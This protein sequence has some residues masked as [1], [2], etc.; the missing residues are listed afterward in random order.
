MVNGCLKVVVFTPP[1][2]RSKEYTF[3][4]SFRL[5]REVTVVSASLVTV[6][7]TAS[8]NWDT[9][10]VTVRPLKVTAILAIP[11][12]LA[13]SMIALDSGTSTTLALTV[14]KFRVSVRPVLPG[15]AAS[16]ASKALITSASTSFRV[17]LSP[18]ML[19]NL[20]TS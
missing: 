17:A 18:T 3:E 11:L 2:V 5:V 20:E 4:A 1:T 15:F 12:A 7:V 8:L 9:G 13:A 19:T 14:P 10:I 6:S 16:N